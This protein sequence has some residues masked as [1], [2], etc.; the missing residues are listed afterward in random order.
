MAYVNP[1]MQ[2][3]D[4]KKYR[5][6]YDNRFDDDDEDQEKF[7]NLGAEISGKNIRRIFIIVLIILVLIPIFDLKTFNMT[8]SGQ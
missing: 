1:N 8:L 5:E 3:F 4:L 7:R 6:I 2:S